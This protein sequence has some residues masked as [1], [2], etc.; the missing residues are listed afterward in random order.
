MPDSPWASKQSL[1]AT[2]YHALPTTAYDTPYP[3]Y[4]KPS[5]NPNPLPPPGLASHTT[6]RTDAWH[7]GAGSLTTPRTVL[8]PCCASG[9]PCVRPPCEPQEPRHCSLAS[10][11]R[12]GPCRLFGHRR[13]SDQD[14]LDHV[15]LQ[16]SVVQARHALHS[17]KRNPV[18][19]LAII[20]RGTTH[21]T[22]RGTMSSAEKSEGC[23]GPSPATAQGQ[24]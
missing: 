3:W 18:V 15:T 2:T 10:W 22:S 20:R 7:A 9:G 8:R 13:S 12:P 11:A 24:L 6:H 17:A 21:R 14:V 5:S 1:H 4:P 23:K 19:A 16:V